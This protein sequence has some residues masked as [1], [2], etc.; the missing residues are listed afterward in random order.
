MRYKL[1]LF[2]LLL[3]MTALGQTDTRLTHLLNNMVKGFHGEVGVC[4]HNLK[5]GET[6]EINADTLFPTASMIKVS[7]LCGLMDKVEKGEIDY[8]QR[9]V[10]TEPLRYDTGDILGSFRN[11]DTIELSKVAMLMITTSDNTASLWLQDMVT[12]EYINHWL[13]QN[14]FEH[15]RVNSRVKGRED[16]RAKYG[17]GVTTSREMCDCLF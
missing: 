10:F 11:G 1:I 4:V 17:W 2:L 16:I 9:L 13:E 5:T 6:A 14:G 3:T 15:T 8:H 7:I 12:G